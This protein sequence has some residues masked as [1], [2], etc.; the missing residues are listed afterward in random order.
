M[1]KN[2]PI[3][4]ALRDIKEGEVIQITLSHGFAFS[5]AIEFN[6]VG[7]EAMYE[8][9]FMGLVSGMEVQSNH[10]KEGHEKDE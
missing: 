5:E 8:M 4:T 6:N 1:K 3:G 2:E 9:A 10:E 7:H